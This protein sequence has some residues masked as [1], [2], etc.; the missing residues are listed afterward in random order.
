MSNPPSG[1]GRAASV[2]PWALAMAWTMALARAPTRAHPGRTDPGDGGAV[3]VRERIQWGVLR[4]LELGEHH[5][6]AAILEQGRGI[7][8]LLSLPTVGTMRSYA[9]MLA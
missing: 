8:I 7:G 9:D 2:A 4:S 3:T 1:R 6:L 5:Y